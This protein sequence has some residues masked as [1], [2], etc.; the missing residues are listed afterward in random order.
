MSTTL[1]V[2]ITGGIGSGKS[3]ICKIFS[4]LGIPIYDADTRAKWLTNN[5][6]EIRSKVI[7]QFGS[8]SFNPNGLDREFLA[9]RVFNDPVQLGILNSIIHPAVGRDFDNWLNQ[10]SSDYVIKEAAL[11]F[12]AGSYKLQDKIITVSAP[13]ELRIQRVLKRDPFRSKEQIEAIIDKQLS[14]EERIERSD[15]V[16]YNDENQ[17]VIPQVIELHQKLKE[18]CKKS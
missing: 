12:E 4:K 11:M 14:E 5:D 3:L 8:K 2:G 9:N 6:P 18:L 1:K 17:M 10:Q 13:V 7:A 15:F 16:I